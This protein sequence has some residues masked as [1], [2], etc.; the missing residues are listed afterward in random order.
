MNKHFKRMLKSLVEFRLDM[1]NFVEFKD[2]AQTEI[3]HSN[4]IIKKEVIDTADICEQMLHEMQYM[5]IK[6][7][8][9]EEVIL[10]QNK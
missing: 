5:Q 3:I 4:R 9:M 6:N 10:K 7:Q 2:S 8:K 1:I